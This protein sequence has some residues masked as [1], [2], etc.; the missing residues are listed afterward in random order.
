[1]QLTKNWTTVKI[2]YEEVGCVGTR[3]RIQIGGPW[4]PVRLDPDSEPDPQRCDLIFRGEVLA[5]GKN[6]F[7]VHLRREL[8]PLIMTAV[9]N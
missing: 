9:L 6:R 7:A 8:Y 2:D 5:T 1:M 3:I 4:M